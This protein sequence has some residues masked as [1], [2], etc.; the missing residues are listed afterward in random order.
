MGYFI[1]NDYKNGKN[2]KNC[3]IAKRSRCFAIILYF[4][5]PGWRQLFVPISLAW[6]NIGA[7]S[8]YNPDATRGLPGNLLAC[9]AQRSSSDRRQPRW[10]RIYRACKKRRMIS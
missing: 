8:T 4:L 3:R 1:W 9:T 7:D 2:R 5:Y 6:Y 10:S